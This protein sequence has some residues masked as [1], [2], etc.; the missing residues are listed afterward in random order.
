MSSDPAAAKGTNSSSSDLSEDIIKLLQTNPE[1]V[2]VEV[3]R[4]LRGLFGNLQGEGSHNPDPTLES[5]NSKNGGSQNP[6]TDRGPQNPPIS[7]SPSETSRG[8][9][10]PSYEKLG[11]NLAKEDRTSEPFGSGAGV[12]TLPLKGSKSRTSKTGLKSSGSERPH[13]VVDEDQS[14]S[15][16]LIEFHSHKKEE[17]ES[18]RPG[19]ADEFLEYIDKVGSPGDAKTAPSG[20]ENR[21]LDA[22]A[23]QRSTDDV[24]EFV[25]SPNTGGQTM[26]MSP[27]KEVSKIDH[28]PSSDD[29]RDPPSP[30]TKNRVPSA[31]SADGGTPPPL[32][33]V[34]LL[35]AKIAETQELVRRLEMV[36]RSERVR[37][38]C[39][40][41]V[42]VVGDRTMRQCVRG[43]FPG[44][45]SGNRT[46]SSDKVR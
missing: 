17:N 9:K 11:T 34:E 26:F 41:S 44:T 37:N 3:L 45:R 23:S 15:F 29:E 46:V 27:V 42:K 30:S 10:N 35:E 39:G 1:K 43:T 28:Q 25:G 21:P 33:E 22:Q 24:P 2:P 16:E 13:D 18:E 5:D 7:Q 32:E 20:T 8:N 36:A 12:E 6:P 38:V 14:S 40:H 19:T 31:V 4:Q